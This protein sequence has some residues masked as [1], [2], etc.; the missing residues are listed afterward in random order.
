MKPYFRIRLLKRVTFPLMQTLGLI[1]FILYV[2]IPLVYRFSPLLQRHLIFLPYLR[3]PVGVNFSRPDVQG[4]NATRNFYLE[5]EAG[6]SV[7]VWHV[8]P[9]SLMNKSY[10]IDDQEKSLAEGY[11]VVLYLHGNSGSRVNNHRLELYKILQSLDYH[12][13]TLDYRGYADSSAALMSENGV[14]TDANAV[15]SYIKKYSSHSRI[16]VWGH[17]LGTGV[18]SRLVSELC[19]GN[20][21]PY[22]LVLESP[23]NN[24]RDEIRSHPL[25]YIFRPIPA[26]DWFFTEPL[27]ANDLA[28]ESDRHIK[29]VNCP[30]LILHAQDDAVIPVFLAKKLYDSAL[31]QRSEQWPSVQLIE[32]D[33]SFGYGHT[34]ICRAPE[35]S[36]IIQEFV[37]PGWT[38]KSATKLIS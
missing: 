5:T 17:S 38:G 26:F 27:K 9:Q 2:I 24:I 12:V 3:W 32:F 7:G 8:L 15:F 35:L 37:E 29:N 23:F 6:V 10:D 14:V 4:L 33:Q 20:D 30:I 36:S 19:L 1:V 18:A 13:I 31:N 21:G 22:G 25:S 11:P 28:F 34:Y 16:V